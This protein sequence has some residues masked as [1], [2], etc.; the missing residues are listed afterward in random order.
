V[1]SVSLEN[2]LLIPQ[3][4]CNILWGRSRHLKEGGREGKEKEMVGGREGESGGGDGWGG[5]V[6]EKKEIQSIGKSERG[7]EKEVR[8][9]F[10]LEAKLVSETSGNS[11][12]FTSIHV[13]LNRA[14][15]ARMKTR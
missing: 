12:L 8:K 6:G 11:N 3:L 14:H 2:H 15:E 5:C 7:R 4:L 1:V 9:I 10:N 13:L